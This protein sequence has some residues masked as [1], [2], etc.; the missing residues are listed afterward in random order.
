[1]LN[2]IQ[3][4]GGAISDEKCLGLESYFKRP[5]GS[6]EGPVEWNTSW[7]R[8]ML[9]T[10]K[11]VLTCDE[12]NLLLDPEHPERL[13][14]LQKTI[15]SLNKKIATQMSEF[16]AKSDCQKRSFPKME[17]KATNYPEGDFAAFSKEA[18]RILKE[19]KNLFIPL[20]IQQPDGKSMGPHAVVIANYRTKCCGDI[21]DT[22]YQIIDSAGFFW[23]PKAYDGWVS[24]ETLKKSLHR[25]S[26]MMWIEALPKVR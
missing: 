26:S 14:D 4:D 13:S 17:V 10:L 1:L 25:S 3:G 8:V 18:Q 21:C 20:F 7:S 9:A 2:A 12:T 5:D 15:E 22:E 23:A 19:G 6:P 24:A 16:V 11:P